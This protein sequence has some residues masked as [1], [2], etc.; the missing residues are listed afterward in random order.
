MLTPQYA[1]M[2]RTPGFI[3]SIAAI[4]YFSITK[5]WRSAVKIS[6]FI[7]VRCINFQY[8]GSAKLPWK[9]ATGVRIC[10]SA[11]ENSLRTWPYL[12]SLYLLRRPW[13][14]SSVTILKDAVHN[15]TI[16]RQYYLSFKQIEPWTLPDWKQVWKIVAYTYVRSTW[17]FLIAYKWQ[18]LIHL[19]TCTWSSATYISACT[20]LRWSV[21]WFLR[22]R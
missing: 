12:V 1:A 5:R 6:V 2:L 20:W 21:L 22:P 8:P 11:V 4:L 3:W 19:S 10:I 18:T 13:N 16:L 9:Q 15:E 14:I 7:N 17:I